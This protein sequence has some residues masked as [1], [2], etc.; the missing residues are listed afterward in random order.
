MTDKWILQDI[1]Q[2]L[3]KRNRVVIV[4]PKA[5]YQFMLP[6]IEKHGYSIIQTDHAIKDGGASVKEEL[7]LR[8][9]LETKYKDKAVVIY[10]SKE[11]SNLSFLFDYCFTHG[12]IDLTNPTEWLKRK[13]FVNTGL[14]VQME[15]PILITAAKL[16]INKDLAWWKKILQNLEELLDVEEELL[17]FIHSPETY[18]D[19]KDADVKRLFEEKIFELIGQ[20]FMKKSAKTLAEEVVKRLFDGLVFNDVPQALLQLYYR[21]ADSEKYKSSLQDYI[22]KY[23]IESA[24][25][26][27]WAAHSD[28]CFSMVDEIALAQITSNIGDKSFVADK[29]QKLK[30]RVNHSKGKSHGA[31]LVEGRIY[32]IRIRL[33]IFKC[34]Y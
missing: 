3:V 8:Y 2:N 11:Q 13:L 25:L 18:F 10:I 9:S 21:W 6:I 27:P 29:I 15:T 20:P 5:Q 1:E 32:N 7:L 16:G 30:A 26:N 12:C 14:Q 31:C 17:P 34:T 4:D 28:H 19:G 23:K 33:K 22:A 24:N